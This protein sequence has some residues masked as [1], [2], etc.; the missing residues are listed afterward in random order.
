[1]GIRAIGRAAAF[2]LALLPGVASA[3]PM[4]LKD[5]IALARRRAPALRAAVARTAIAEANRSIARA[6]YLPTLGV[7]AGVDAG[8]TSGPFVVEGM[9]AEVA[10][11]SLAA[12]AALEA[13]WT[14]V[15]FGRT[16]N[17]ADA[18]DAEAEV[19]AA[20]QRE[21]AVTIATEAAQ[22]YYTVVY[23]RDLLE[24][25]QVTV[26]QRERHLQLAQGLVASGLRAPIEEIR[27]RVALDGA[28]RQ[29]AAT[30]ARVAADRLQLSV[31]TGVDESSLQLEAPPELW[32]DDEPARAAATALRTRPAVAAAR[33]SVEARAAAVSAATSGRLPTIQATAEGHYRFTQRDDDPRYLPSRQGYA[34][35]VVVVPI[36][37]ASIG[38]RVD[39]ARANLREA[40][41][42]QAREQLARQLAAGRAAI[43]SRAARR[44]LVHAEHVA[45]GAAAAVSILEG[46]YAAGVV[47]PLELLDAAATDAAARVAVVAA[48][49]DVAVARVRLLAATGQILSL[50]GRP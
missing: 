49:L 7:R 5:M 11:R 37:D 4:G 43:E 22:L 26:R 30:E 31:L 41:A 16:A 35:I 15:D 19:A 2:A 27:A 17:A 42:E 47:S 40:E 6:P 3:A 46:R 20:Q 28:R 29:L 33:A 39:V 8:V 9:T 45:Q 50:E 25:A 32:V 1:M 44:V 18:A 48:R 34:G 23:D 36:F 21:T 14:I 38:A 13:R 12:D 24:Q 10:T